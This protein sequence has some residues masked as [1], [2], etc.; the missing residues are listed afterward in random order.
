M[1]D[2]VAVAADGQ[3][4]LVQLIRSSRGSRVWVYLS[5]LCD[6]TSRNRPRKQRNLSSFFQRA[7]LSHERVGNHRGCDTGFPSSFSRKSS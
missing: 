6:G 7:A 1:K 2:L 5:T 4:A 3:R